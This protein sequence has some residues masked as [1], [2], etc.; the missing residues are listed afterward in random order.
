MQSR[1]LQAL[2]LYI[3]LL[4]LA[5]LELL[6]LLLLRVTL[7]RQLQFESRVLLSRRLLKLDHLRDPLLLD[8]V[9]VSSYYVLFLNF[10]SSR[11]LLLFVFEF[12]HFL[13]TEALVALDSALLLLEDDQDI[14]RVLLHYYHFFWKHLRRMVH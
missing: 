1:W 13:F 5:R 8:L 11:L 4:G 12:G 14:G 6:V 9:Q 3:L 7:G 10:L 2:A